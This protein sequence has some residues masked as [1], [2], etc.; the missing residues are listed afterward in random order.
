M[1]LIVLWY[2]GMLATSLIVALGA[3]PMPRVSL[4]TAFPH[5]TQIYGIVSDHE[6]C[7]GG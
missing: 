6:S 4:A 1:A 7:D 2:V 5:T 3:L